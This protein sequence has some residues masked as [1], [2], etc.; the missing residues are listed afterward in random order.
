MNDAQSADSPK[1]STGFLE[2]WFGAGKRYRF[3]KF[4]STRMAYPAIQERRSGL[5]AW[6]ECDVRVPLT[7]PVNAMLENS[8]NAFSVRRFGK[9]GIS[10]IGPDPR[11]N[12]IDGDWRR[13]RF[14][15]TMEEEDLEGEFS[16]GIEFLP[17]E[18][19]ERKLLY[20]FR[21][22]PLGQTE[23]E[24]WGPWQQPT[25]VRGGVFGWHAEIHQEGKPAAPRDEAGFELRCRIR[26]RDDPFPRSVGDV[27]ELKR[28]LAD[29][30]KGNAD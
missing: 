22:A 23:P 4:R 10:S 13:W 3:A 15:T 24:R 14:G 8:S 11:V 18:Q 30:A 6:R 26:L 28:Q 2:K 17:T 21:Q 1:R 7:H 19:L 16:Y 29:E 20:L 12:V 9:I 5:W 27:E 25:G